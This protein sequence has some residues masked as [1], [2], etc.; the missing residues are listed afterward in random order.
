MS[1]S[2]SSVLFGGTFLVQKKGTG[3]SV[4]LSGSRG[5]SIVTAEHRS[6]PKPALRG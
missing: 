1:G 3:G 4:S 6:I 2:L 5:I